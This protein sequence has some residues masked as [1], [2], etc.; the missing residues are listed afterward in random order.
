MPPGDPA[1]TAGP[2]RTPPGSYTSATTGRPRRTRT[3]QTL[4]M[5][6]GV[7]LGRAASALLSESSTVRGEDELRA[8]VPG[9]DLF[10]GR[11]CNADIRM[12]LA[13]AGCYS[14]AGGA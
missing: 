14:A 12:L 9:T 13:P 11:F 4:A 3:D 10:V 7:H 6:D 8:L 1:L 2:E 5:I